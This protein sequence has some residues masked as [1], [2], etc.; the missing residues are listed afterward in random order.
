MLE[1]SYPKECIYIDDIKLCKES[2]VDS[3]LKAAKG[4]I[5]GTFLGAC[6]WLGII[7]LIYYSL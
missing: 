3:N 1:L 5:Y 4:I 6:F 2:W 7:A